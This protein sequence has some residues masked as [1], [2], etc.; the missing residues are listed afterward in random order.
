MQKHKD[1]RRPVVL[2]IRL[3]KVEYAQL[4]DLANCDQRTRCSM[5][6]KLIASA[7]ARQQ[8]TANVR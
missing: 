3:S 1:R 6:R 4:A 8:E 2:P 5:I 7:A